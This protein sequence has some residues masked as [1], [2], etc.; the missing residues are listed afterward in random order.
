MLIVPVPSGLV[1]EMGTSRPLDWWSTPNQQPR[2]VTK[3]N[4]SYSAYS[5]HAHAHKLFLQW[6]D[7]K[8][9]TQIDEDRF[10]REHCDD[11]CYKDYNMTGTMYR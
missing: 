1:W 10:N 11:A 6:F 3:I 7:D 9:I 5:N 8:S 2:S 4:Y